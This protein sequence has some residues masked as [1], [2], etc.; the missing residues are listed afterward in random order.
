MVHFQEDIITFAKHLI[1]IPTVNPPGEQYEEC[2]ALIQKHCDKL[3]LET[4]VVTCDGLP[5]LIGGTGRGILHFHAH[6]DV[7]RGNGSQFHPFL[8]DGKLYGRGAS[9]MKGGLAAMLYALSC[10]DSPDISFSITADEE[11][12]GIHGVNCLLQRGLLRPQA[13]LMPEASSNRI[14]NGCWGAFAAQITV[15]GESS[16]S[17]YQERGTN[18]F[19]DMIDVVQYFRNQRP[20]RGS[21]LLGG[22]LTGGTQFN[23]VPESCSFSIDWRFPP[24][25]T[26][27]S[28][29]TS[30]TEIMENMQKE[31]ISLSCTPLLETEGFF[32]PPQSEIVKTMK[33]AVHEVRGSCITQVC[34][35]FLDIRYFAFRGIPAIAYGPGLLEYAHGPQEYIE[36]QDL[37][38]A[39]SIYQRVARSMMRQAP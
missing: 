31:G 5:A 14:W 9:D 2:I 26:L 29:T 21:L 15:K 11:T 25:Q 19:I 4:T 34:P 1:E 32:T 12:G 16:H 7:V 37:M 33:K 13:V 27:S 39:V 22:A 20:E 8:K 6:Y 36:V 23:M 24:E 3:G 38:D 10:L 35:G 17:I 28:I 18:A 30:V